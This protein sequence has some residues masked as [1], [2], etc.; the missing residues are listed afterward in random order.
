MCWIVDHYLNVLFLG[1]TREQALKVAEKLGLTVKREEAAD[2]FQKLYNLFIKYDVNMIEIN[3]LAED[4]SG[5]RMYYLSSIMKKDYVANFLC[6]L[7]SCAWMRKCGLTIMQTSVNPKYFL[8]EIGL[9]KTHK[10]L[11]LRIST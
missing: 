2:M 9:R 5:Q 11:K 7:Q 10:K 3:P 8:T 4:S 6:L 1:L